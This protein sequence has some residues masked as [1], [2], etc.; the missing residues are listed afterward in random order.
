MSIPLKVLI[1]ED[2]PADSEL[3]LHELRQAGFAPEAIQAEGE[4]EFR[5][6]LEQKPQIILADYFLP[7]YDALLALRQLQQ[8]QLDIPFIVISG[9]I[10][11][12]KAVEVVREGATDYLLKDRLARLG[13]AVLRALEEQ[14]LRNQKRQ[15]ER[16]LR[17][18]EQHLSKL[19]NEFQTLLNGIPDSLA[20][21]TENLQ[22]VWANRGTH[23][24]LCGD[25][26]KIVGG[27]CH[28]LWHQ[29][30][31]PC[32]DCPAL[33]S[34][35]T[36]QTE[37]ATINSLDGRTWGIKT[38]PLRDAGGRVTHVIHWASDISEKI[39]LRQEA[40][41]SAHLAALGELAAGVAHEINNPNG[42]ILLNLPVI[43]AA[44]EDAKP[45]LDAHFR[46]QGDFPLGGLPYSEICRELPHLLAEIQ[47]GAKR[48]KRIVEELKDYVRP[49]ISALFRDF[50]LNQAVMTG[51]RLAESSLRKAA[52][53]FS[54]A[55]AESLPPVFGNRQRI[56]QVVVN[57]L[58]NACQALTGS[59]QAIA[60]ETAWDAE[61]QMCQILVRD[62]GVGI[63][64]KKLNHLTE[65]FFTTR[66]ESGG[67]GLGLSVSARIIR[68]HGGALYFDSLPGRGTTVTVK[69]PAASSHQP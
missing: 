61:R 11:E 44:F 21:L 3:M 57:L 67:T 63:P 25:E 19:N 14:R 7:Q 13:T 58:T 33:K 37:D 12:E 42:L 51:V 56:E 53:R 35:R 69:L 16:A 32:N 1:L 2:N 45:I 28:T 17:E 50:D 27:Y 52:A 54:I 24:L 40:D 65:P 49:E 68:E 60:V 5:R 23:A 4:T 41:R 39:R 18:R 8:R 64:A 22:I 55:C 15:V 43:M 62:E 10:G 38:F 30:A 9:S 34:F 29:S 6:G 48:I 36:G 31:G 46:K 47:D 26:K 66:R 20:L 59:D